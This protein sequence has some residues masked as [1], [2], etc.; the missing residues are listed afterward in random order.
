MNHLKIGDG[1]FNQLFYLFRVIVHINAQPLRISP[2][3]GAIYAGVQIRITD[4]EF[5]LTFFQGAASEFFKLFEV[6]IAHIQFE[7]V[8]IIPVNHKRF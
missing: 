7:V 4:Q 2:G 6:L 8:H 1:D 3:G 5:A